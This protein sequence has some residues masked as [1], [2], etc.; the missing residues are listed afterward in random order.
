MACIHVEIWAW[1]YVKGTCVEAH[2]SAEVNLLRNVI[3]ST[4]TQSSRK[5]KANFKP[6]RLPEE[7]SAILHIPV[8]YSTT[9]IYLKASDNY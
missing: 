6:V 9:Y 7:V 4:P 2:C 1:L 3:I 5:I 8:D